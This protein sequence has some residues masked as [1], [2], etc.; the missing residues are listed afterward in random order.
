MALRRSNLVAIA[1]ILSVISQIEK[2]FSE[3]NRQSFPKPF[4]FGTAASAFQV[5]LFT[6][7]HSNIYYLFAS[8]LFINI[9][10]NSILKILTTFTFEL[11]FKTRIK[12]YKNL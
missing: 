4:V 10:L 11:L 1:V 3:I 8:P 2:C 9:F 5:F 7:Q 6:L 12:T